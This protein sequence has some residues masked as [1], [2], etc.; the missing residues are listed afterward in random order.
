MSHHVF[1]KVRLLL[2]GY[3]TKLQRVQNCLARVVTNYPR[4]THSTPLLKSLQW[5]PFRYRIIVNIRTVTYQGFTLKQPSYLHS[6]LTP[7]RKPAQR[8]PS[9]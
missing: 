4:F 5:V 8:R 9:S 2:E 6:L 7:V 1:E 3:I